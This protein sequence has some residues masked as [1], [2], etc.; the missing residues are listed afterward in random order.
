MSV[1]APD[2]AGRLDDIVLGFDTLEPYLKAQPF[3]G[4]LVGRYGNRI[5]GGQFTPRRQG[6]LTCRRTTARTPC[7]AA[8]SGF[9]KVLWTS[10]E[11]T[12]RGRRRASS[13][14]T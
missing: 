10:R 1:K 5:G 4:A 12:G 3:F 11:V 8:T 9:D 13:S 7:T 14:P 6:L 2:R